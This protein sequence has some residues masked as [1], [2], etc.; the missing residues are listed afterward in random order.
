MFKGGKTDDRSN[1]PLSVLPVL[2]K[3]VECYI[4]D[5]F[6]AS[7]SEN[8][9]ISDHGQSKF[10]KQLS[11]ETA[12][13]KIIDQLT[14]LNK[15]HISALTM[16][17]FRKEEHQILLMKLGAYSVAKTSSSWFQSYLINRQQFVPIDGSDTEPSVIKHGVPWGS[18]LESL[19]FILF[20]N[21]LLFYVLSSQIDL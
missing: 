7:L 10:R 16:I 21:N 11:S 20:I 12:V 4:H 3:V 15:D 1:F 14:N 2:S 13:V 8:N 6:Y 5:C 19:S 9:L 17:D 18:I